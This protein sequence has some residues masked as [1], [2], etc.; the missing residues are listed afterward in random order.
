METFDDVLPNNKNSSGDNS[1][2]SM[3]SA[4]LKQQYDSGN[5]MKEL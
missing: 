5:P 3:D 1:N 2:L 4:I